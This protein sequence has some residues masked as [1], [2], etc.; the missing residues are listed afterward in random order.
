MLVQSQVP[1]TAQAG[2]K[3]Q[4]TSEAVDSLGRSSGVQVFTLDVSDGTPPSI[5][6]L[7]PPENTRLTPSVPLDL[8]VRASDNSTNVS[9]N[10]ALSGSLVATQMISM[11][12]APNTP[13]TNLF[14]APLSNAFP[15]G[16]LLT[17]TVTASD[18]VGNTALATRNFWLPPL[19]TSVVTWDR[20]ALGQTFNCTNGAGT[21]TW[22]N[23]NNWSQSAQFGDPCHTGQIVETAPSN[24]STTNYPADPTNDVVLGSLGGAPANLDVPVAV[25]S[26]T[27]QSNGGLNLQ[28][29]KTLTAN[30]FDFQGDSGISV[31]GGGGGA[32]VLALTLG[33]T[34]TKSAG[35][36]VFAIDPR[37]ALT[38]VEGVISVQSGTLAL[39][40][41]GSS[42][43]NETFT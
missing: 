17:A 36:G 11:A 6:I 24:W 42:Y 38:S 32:P 28:L 26:L 4:I 40:A 21:Y 35:T 5:A 7:G 27:I 9:L 1:S 13:V 33:G 23:N 20:Q 14:I 41:A 25:N 19:A 29:G 12:L 3:I 30:A 43:S 22:P 39:P 18:T 2:H 10:L 8:T 37:A 15:S 34:L 31:G 16:G